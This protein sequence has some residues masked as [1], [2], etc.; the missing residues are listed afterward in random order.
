MRELLHSM[1]PEWYS[2]ENYTPINPGYITLGDNNDCNDDQEFSNSHKA[3][4]PSIV[5]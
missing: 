3:Y 4:H 5:V 1:A 2:V